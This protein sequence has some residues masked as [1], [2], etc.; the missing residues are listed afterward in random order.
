[1]KT[2]RKKMKMVKVGILGLVFLLMAGMASAALVHLD[3]IALTVNP[4]DTVAV[5][6][7]GSGF[8]DGAIGGSIL[9]SWDPSIMTFNTAAPI[10][11]WITLG[12]SLD[13]ATATFDFTAVNFAV[14]PPGDGGVEFSFASLDF[15]ALAAPGT[16]LGVGLGSGGDWQD[17]NFASITD[18]TYQGASITVVNPV[19][20][21]G[22]VWLLGSGLFGLVGVVR[23]RAA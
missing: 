1:M 17:G 18:V 2:N 20:V 6:V 10:A 14:P 21:P 8:L 23:R 16:I 7:K 19:P 15:T 11:P 4:G 9:L 22:A 13:A 3:P 5:T 12:A